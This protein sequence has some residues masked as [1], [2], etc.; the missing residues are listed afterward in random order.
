LLRISLEGLSKADQEQARQ[1]ATKQNPKPADGT[2]NP[3]VVLSAPA[4]ATNP[5]RDEIVKQGKAATALV[6]TPS[7]NGGAAAKPEGWMQTAAAAFRSG[8]ST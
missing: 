4:G 6:L 7:Q 5:V 3:F 8:P 2:D 1:L